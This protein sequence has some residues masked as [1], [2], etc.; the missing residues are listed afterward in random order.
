[1]LGLVAFGLLILALSYYRP[2]GRPQTAGEDAGRDVESGGNVDGDPNK[3]VKVYEEKVLV[4]MAGEGRPT[5][6]ATPVTTGTSSL[7]DK[8][9]NFYG[10][11]GSEKADNGV[12][13]KEEMG[14]S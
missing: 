12:K 8:S 14:N 9:G 2:S 13:V 10:G 11:E 4:I 1:M 7:G 3:P 5:F 6:L